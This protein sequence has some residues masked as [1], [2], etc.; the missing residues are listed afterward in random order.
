M[1]ILVA[2]FSV[3]TQTVS[4]LFTTVLQAR[5]L[6]DR[7]ELLQSPAWDATLAI[8]RPVF[9]AC[10]DDF[11]YTEPLDEAEVG[12]FLTAIASGNDGVRD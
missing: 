9:D 12:R 8:D 3:S 4:S 2:L 10:R 1:G 6:N 7:Q 11:D 5:V